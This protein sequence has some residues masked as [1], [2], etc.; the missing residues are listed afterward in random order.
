MTVTFGAFYDPKTESTTFRVWAPRPRS[1]ALEI[2]GVADR[3]PLQPRG[4]GVFE[5]RVE[6]IVPGARYF[7]ILDGDKQRP[8][9]ASRAQPDGVHGASMVVD[10][11][12]PWQSPKRPRLMQERVLYE[13]HVGTFTRAGTFDAVIEHL[14]AL[15]DLGVTD[16][17]ILPVASFSGTR[18]WGY[19]GVGWFAPQQSYGGPDGLRRLVDAC[20]A[21]GLGLVL[22]V[23]YNHFGP[24]GSYVGEF[25]PWFTKRHQTPWGD[26]IDYD[27]EHAKNVRAHVIANAE[28]W[29]EDYRIDGL[30]LD[31]V[32]AIADDSPRHI[33]GE[34][35]ALAHQRGGFIIAESDL[36]DVKIITGADDGGWGCD[37]QWSDDFHHALHAAVTGEKKGYYED[38]GTVAQLATALREGF[39]YQGQPS[40]HRKKNFGTRSAHVP[41]ERFVICAQNHDQIGNRAVGERLAHLQPGCEHA[42]AATLLLAPATPM[43]FMGEE[44]A[45]PAPFQYF[46]DH[47]DQHLAQLV[48]DGRRREFPAWDPGDV[49]DPQAAETH[50]RSILDLSLAG[51]GRHA[52]VRRWYKALLRIRRER[53]EVARIDKSRATTIVDEEH[54]GLVLIRGGD[55]ADTAVAVSLRGRP[56]SFKLPS[57]IDPRRWKILLDAGDPEFGG[58]AGTRLAGDELHLPP[59]GALV[60]AAE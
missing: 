57:L 58:P 20:H 49:P 37:A 1:I 27:G 60:L 59:W 33:V 9:P 29:L 38:F 35:A 48:R 13:L 7:Y 50:A 14:D 32:H 54:G 25:A 18:N 42:V 52:A 10:R 31:A 36:G 12:W 41:G 17:E 24:E 4:D 11:R 55:K 22:D 46:T 19:D 15:V 47:Q 51:R 16:V 45:D 8:D 34:V 43:L 28:M 53:Q 56:V 44:H 40:R 21:R 3:V 23:V 6:G 2:S 30:R 26:G 39:V 5:A